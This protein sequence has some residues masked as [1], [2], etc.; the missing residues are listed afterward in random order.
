MGPEAGLGAQV[1]DSFEEAGS[2]KGGQ[3]TREDGVFKGLRALKAVGSGGVR[4][5]VLL[6]VV[7]C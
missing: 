2:L 4:L 1:R 5:E 3:E 7:C 6:R